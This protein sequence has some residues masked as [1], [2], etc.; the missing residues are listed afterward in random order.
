[1]EL[2]ELRAQFGAE[3]RPG[4]STD[5]GPSTEPPS[6]RPATCFA[7]T[8]C[9]AS[10][11]PTP[12][13]RG[14][15]PWF[16]ACFD[17]SL[18]RSDLG[19]H[20]VALRN[21]GIA[22]TE[23]RFGFFCFTAEWLARRF[24]DRMRIDWSAFE[25]RADLEK[26]L[27]LL[28]LYTETPAL[29]EY[30]LPVRQWIDRFRG[31]DTDAAFLIRRFRALRL[32]AFVREAIYEGLDVPLRLLPGPRTPSRTLAEHRASPVV[33]Q[34]APLTKSRPSLPEEVRRPPLAIRAVSLGEGRRLIALAREAMVTRSRDLDVFAH[35]DASDVRLVEC[36]AACSSR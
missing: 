12:T 16:G 22:G 14:S 34:T 27:H 8:R 32:D 5:C 10:C 6:R 24:G 35:G 23:I 2:E 33:Y 30:A 20:K 21:T 11:G 1:M 26:L 19:R 9:S 17:A 25:R 36:G 3:R 18:E 15:W 13:A 31:K 7:S 29:D 28:V 4:S